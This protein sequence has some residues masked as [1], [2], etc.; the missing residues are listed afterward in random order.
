MQVTASFVLFLCLTFVSFCEGLKAYYKTR[1]DELA[2]VLREKQQNLRRL[3]AQRNDLNSKGMFVLRFAY[4]T[5]GDYTHYT[6]LVC[7]YM[8]KT[9]QWARFAMNCR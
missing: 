4:Y 6:V 3:E 2:L 1:L 5:H 8:Q 7:I 9:K